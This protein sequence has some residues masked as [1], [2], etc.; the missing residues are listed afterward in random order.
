M[1]I[2]IA[3]PLYPPETAEPAPYVKELAKH[4]SGAHEITIVAYA[5]TSEKIKNAKLITIDKRRPLF[6]R[7]TKYLIELF[8]ASRNADVIYMQNSLAVGLPALIV[9]YLRNT[10]V[11][12]RFTEDEG[13]KRAFYARLTKKKLNEFLDK[14]DVGN[15]K[16][17]L[18]MRAQ[19]F[20]LRRAQVIIVP[21][22]CLRDALIKTYRL[23]N[24]KFIVNCDP[25]KKEVILPFPAIKI[26]RQII[27]ITDKENKIDKIIKAVF[28]LKKEF[29]DI[30]LIIA[31]QE[32]TRAERWHLYK[33]SQ[34]CVLNSAEEFSE[35]AIDCF[36]A[37]IPVV[38]AGGPDTSEENIANAISKLLKNPE[39]RENLVKNAQETLVKKFSW[40]AHIRILYNALKSISVKN[41]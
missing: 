29:P 40:T 23:Q 26:P 30:Q 12:I 13:W 10:P 36:N 20:I 16:I 41:K 35:T 38:S 19:G 14:P 33:T 4:L 22:E 28:L 17:R 15:L 6:I 5:S 1:K 32:A 21:S 2:I 37:G 18:I 25:A 34:I 3:T 11:A 24:K 7:L 31:E 39:L 27:T 9:G 8:K